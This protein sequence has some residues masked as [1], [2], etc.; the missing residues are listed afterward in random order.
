MLRFK[1]CT[2]LAFLLFLA[3]P[4]DAKTQTARWL[5]SPQQLS[6]TEQKLNGWFDVSK[7][8]LDMSHALELIQATIGSCAKEAAAGKPYERE[9][10]APPGGKCQSGQTAFP[11]GQD[12]FII[13]V[14]RWNDPAAGATTQTM[15]K[16]NWYTFNIDPQWSN[17]DFAS[18]NRVFGKK[19]V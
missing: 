16:Q 14:L 17:E 12:Y 7:A 1:C 15:D 18:N 8:T 2:C 13:H 6:L 4:C 11:T 10:E 19:R 9:V 3:S 5:S